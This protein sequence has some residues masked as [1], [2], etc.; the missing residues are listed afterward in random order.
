MPG[1]IVTSMCTS[2]KQEL[3]EAGH[4][5]NATITFTGTLT[6]N[7]FNITSVSSFTGLA[8]GM[9]LTGTAIP[10][11]TVIAAF[12]GTNEIIM[13]AEATAPE[14][15]ETITAIGDVYNIA[16]IKYGESGTYNASSTNYSNITGNNDEVSSANYTA[17][18]QALT[19]VSPV[20]A[21]S[22]D[23]TVYVNFSP[24]PSWTGVSFSAE[25]CMIYNTSN[26]LGSTGRAVGVFDFGGEQTVN[27]GTFTILMPVAA[28]TT[29]ILRLE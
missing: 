23:T 10:S 8:V 25:G 4:N 27:D 24:N 13:S 22:P 26:R 6:D 11:D 21:A 12:S 18:G 29:A 2:F 19:N 28:G 17:G 14:S 9:A 15:G 20:I 5:F 1:S 16:I 7:S 3:M